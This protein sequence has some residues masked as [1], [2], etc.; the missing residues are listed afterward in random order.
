MSNPFLHPPKITR[1]SF[2]NTIFTDQQVFRWF[3]FLTDRPTVRAAVSGAEEMNAT[4]RRLA[5]W[6]M[7]H[8]VALAGVLSVIGA[9]ILTQHYALALLLFPLW[10]GLAVVERPLK[11]ALHTISR[12]VVDIHYD[13]ASFTRYTLYQIGERL[14]R[15][16]GVRSLVD[17][18]A[19]TDILL[20]RWLII[21]AFLVVFLFVMSFWRG[22]L[23][24]FILYF[25]GNIVMNADPVYR[26][27]M[28]CTTPATKITAR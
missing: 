6:R 2:R 24:I 7:W 25:A 3:L 22:A 20:R 15:E 5:R 28:K 1:Q 10:G 16:Y 9:V 26:R 14:G 13:E 27:Y 21:V 11:E 17:G 18:I 12:A 23:M 4:Y 8:R 19:W